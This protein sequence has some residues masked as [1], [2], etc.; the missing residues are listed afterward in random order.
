MSRDVVEIFANRVRADKRLQE[1]FKKAATS[2]EAIL[3]FAKSHGCDVTMEE[4]AA[5]MNQRKAVLSE[6]SLDRVTGGKAKNKAKVNVQVAATTVE[7][8]A[9]VEA[10]VSTTTAVM[11]A[12]VVII[13]T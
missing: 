1:E 8:A 7:V 9:V 11:S 13:A 5:Y 2:N 4:L 10:G 6:E 3:Q 12:E